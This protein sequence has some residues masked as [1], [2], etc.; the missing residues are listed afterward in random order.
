MKILNLENVTIIR[1]FTYS[2][3][4]LTS[5]LVTEFCL[6]NVK[7]ESCKQIVVAVMKNN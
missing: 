4:I 2:C 5:N 7:P 6:R 1:V 3:Q